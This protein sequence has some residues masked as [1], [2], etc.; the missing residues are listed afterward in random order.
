MD[1]V[2]VFMAAVTESNILQITDPIVPFWDFP[3][4]MSPNDDEWRVAIFSNSSSSC[5]YFVNRTFTDWQMTLGL[6]FK[7]STTKINFLAPT[8]AQEMQMFVCLFGEKCSR[9]HNIHLSLLGQS[10]VSLRSVWGLLRS[11]SSY[12]IDQ[13]EPKILCLVRI[14]RVMF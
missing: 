14:E 7:R 5:P 1:H 6:W 4:L 9:A 2:L 10:Q 11:L 8:G 3:H 12:F 13:T